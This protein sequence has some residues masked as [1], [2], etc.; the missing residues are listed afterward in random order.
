MD[1][2]KTEAVDAFPTPTST[3]ELRSFLGLCNFYR[4]FVQG[5][6]T[7]AAPLN[8]LLKKDTSYSWTKECQEAFI[9]LKTKLVSAPILAYP[10]MTKGFILTTDASATAIGYILSQKLD[11]IEHPIAY[12]GRST[13]KS[14]K[15]YSIADLECLAVLEGIR[16]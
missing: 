11:G 4:R 7:V 3:K 1:P 2:R 15:N 8:S 16:A 10:D 13:R 12:G 6:A 5:Y 14:E 9:T